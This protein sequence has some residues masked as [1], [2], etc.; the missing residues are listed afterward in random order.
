MHGMSGGVQLEW[1]SWEKPVIH[2]AVKRLMAGFS[3]GER[4]FSDVLFIVPTAEAGRRLK[5]AL[6]RAAADH[7]GGVV[8]PHVWAPERLLMTLADRELAATRLQSWLAWTAILNSLREGECISLLGSEHEGRG[9]RWCL[10]T[11]E[12]MLDL[13]STLGAG[14]WT[15]RSVSESGHAAA[16]AA[17]WRDLAVLE[18]RYLKLLGNAGLR[19]VQAVKRE[20]A[21]Q[22]WLPD[23]VTSVRVMGAPDLPPLAGV[24]L[25][26]AA[27][28]LPVHVSVLAPQDVR[29]GFDE[30]GRPLPAFWSDAAALGAAVRLEDIRVEANPAGQ[31][32]AVVE[33][34][35]E[36]AVQYRTAVGVCDPEV[37][38]AILERMKG[39][40]VHVFEPGGAAPRHVGLWHVMECFQE[41]L[42]R[43]TWAAFAKLLRVQ[44]VREALCGEGSAGLLEKADEFATEHMPLTLAHARSLMSD[45]KWLT[46]TVSLERLMQWRSD[47]TKG[48]VETLIRHLLLWIYGGRSFVPNA[49]ADRLHVELAEA[50]LETAAE[51]DAGMG[52]FGEERPI[53]DRLALVM[54]LAGTGMLSEPRGDVDLVLQGWLE[55]LWEEA[56]GLVVAGVNEEHVP[57]ILI[58]HPFLPDGLR[59]KLG[60]PC[61]ATRYARD[62]YL[63]HALN[64]QRSPGSLRW[65]CGQWS[66]RGDALKPSRLL[67]R[68]ENEELP[69]RV[70]HLFPRDDESGAALEPPRTIAW[71]LR[72]SLLPAR[73]LERMSPSRL[74]AYLRCPFGYYLDNETRWGDEINPSKREMDALEFGNLIHHS[75]EQFARHATLR[76]SENAVEIADF[77]DATVL[78]RAKEVWGEPLPMLV[79]LQV[80]G[81]RQRL[82]ALADSEA[83]ARQD[84]WQIM[85]AEL[86]IGG[87]DDA[88][89]VLIGKARLRGKIDRVERRESGGRSQFRI[90]DFKTSDKAS[91]PKK[92]HLNKLSARAK[93][94]EED[95]W[96]RV[97]DRDGKTWHEW[98]GLQLPLYAAALQARGFGVPEVGYFCLPK[99]V[100]ETGVRMW[101]G[102]DEWWMKQALMVAEEVVRRIEAGIFWP[103][104]DVERSNDPVFLGDVLATVEWPGA[105]QTG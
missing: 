50:L 31:A 58:S 13:S 14:G 42:E 49:P 34:V 89:P 56:A 63:I 64:A 97:L 70:R 53:Q 46:L 19:D 85:E 52:Q 67:M 39:E 43:E 101:E 36:L 5:E 25:Q 98:T 18:E 102:F 16:D 71:R 9:W 54:K 32:G 88:T 99:S 66:D 69:R 37:S 60:L 2:W 3:G 103:P 41:V 11:A 21:L 47:A 82:R 6:A 75:L 93:S 22:P 77:L 24:W 51:V 91:D 105:A 12:M 55:L 80:E 29:A 30:A 84:G 68:C 7:G 61:Q 90:L 86:P 59:E 1:W 57:G 4:D 94:Q 87:D 17:R 33:A 38:S 92:A 20:R 81:A 72:P 10:S 79:R 96:K 78:M 65:I 27:K 8:A 35:G 95:E 62:A 74:A 15:F 45:A 100:Q 76:A 40:G 73:K 44:D 48:S 23:G 28:E 104:V 26:Q 83:A